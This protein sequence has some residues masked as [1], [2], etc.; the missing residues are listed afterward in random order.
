VN[1]KPGEDE[2]RRPESAKRTPASA[3]RS[4]NRTLTLRQPA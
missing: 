3:L 4:T 1:L 2:A